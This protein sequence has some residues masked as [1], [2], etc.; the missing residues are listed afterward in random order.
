MGKFL[1]TMFLTLAC[2]V[3]LTAC[4]EE[5]LYTGLKERE[6]NEMA[7]VLMKAGIAANRIKNLTGNTYDLQLADKRYFSD[8]VALL[9]DRGYPRKEYDDFGKVFKGDG[10]VSTPTEIKARYIYAVTQQ[11]ER[12]LTEIGGVLNARVNVVMP[13]SDPVTRQ[14]LPATASVVVT[15]DASLSGNALIP[16]IKQIVAA[17]VD[18]LSYDG[19]SVM[20]FARQL[21]APEPEAGSAAT[22]MLKSSGTSYVT[23]LCFAVIAAVLWWLYG[24]GSKAPKPAARAPSRSLRVSN[25]RPAE[26]KLRKKNPRF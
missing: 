11:L 18:G 17:S 21:K 1:R 8:A 6:V 19:V 13:E 15:H 5:T 7:A 10:L 9:N 23:I 20:M 26:T 2:G 22:S 14:R 25:T 4:N 16:K 24:G 3:L 12:T